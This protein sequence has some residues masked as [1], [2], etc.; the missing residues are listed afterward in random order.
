MGISQLL[1]VVNIQIKRTI[2]QLICHKVKNKNIQVKMQGKKTNLS[3]LN[4][5]FQVCLVYSPV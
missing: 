4:A 5:H 1:D 3:F 2:W